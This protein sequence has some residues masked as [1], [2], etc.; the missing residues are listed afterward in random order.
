LLAAGSVSYAGSS[1][2]LVKLRAGLASRRINM[3][4]FSSL[5]TKKNILVLKK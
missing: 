1:R 2:G 5:E 3:T 4:T